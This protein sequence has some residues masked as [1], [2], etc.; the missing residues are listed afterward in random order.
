ML[1]FAQ[2]VIKVS[3]YTELKVGEIVE[4]IPPHSILIDK[5]VKQALKLQQNEIAVRRI[6]KPTDNEDLDD[7]ELQ[8]LFKT[9]ESY[10][11]L[12]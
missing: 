6:K 1:P 8:E 5:T 3:P 10:C 11:I 12:L 4:I 9:K 7:E 2:A